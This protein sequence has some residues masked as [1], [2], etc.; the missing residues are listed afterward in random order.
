MAAGRAK[1]SRLVGRYQLVFELAQSY[2]GPL[3]AVCTDGDAAAPPSLLRLVSLG[4]QDADTRVRLLEAAWQAMEVSGDH[5][6]AVTDVVA[7]DGEL[8]VVC[9]YIEGLPLRALQGLSSA[10]RKPVPPSLA[11]RLIQDIAE[12]VSVLHGAA[13]GLGEEGA[14]L[15]GGLSPDSVIVTTEGRISLLDT[16]IAGVASTVPSLGGN[17]ER[18]AYSSPEQLGS[19]PHADARSDVFTLGVLAWELLSNRRLFIGSDKAVAQRV[20]S[21]KI[22]RPDEM[23]R[24][25]DPEVPA[26]IVATVMKALDRNPTAR[27]QSALAFRDALLG[28][29]SAVDEPEAVAEY[30]RAV[31]DGAL[32][33]LREALKD[34]STG[35]RAGVSAAKAA[36]ARASSVD[37][38]ADMAR[39]D[40]H[41]KAP[42]APKH[43]RPLPAIRLE[44]PKPVGVPKPEPKA[45]PLLAPKVDPRAPVAA[46]PAVPVP[47]T[48]DAPSPPAA[49]PPA[50]GAGAPAVVRAPVPKRL[51]T[52]IGMMSP[53]AAKPAAGPPSSDRATVKPNMRPEPDGLGEFLDDPESV[54]P[55]KPKAP[56]AAAA[57]ATF[58]HSD[59]SSLD[60]DEPTAQF[61]AKDLVQVERMARSSDPAHGPRSSRTSAA[62]DEQAP[63]SEPLAWLDDPESVRAP[64]PVA[65]PAFP[66]SDARS[67]AR[68]TPVG[69]SPDARPT[70]VLSPGALPA[71]VRPSKAAAPGAAATSPRREE[72]GS[73]PKAPVHSQPP[74]AYYPS[75][76]PPPLIHDPRANRGPSPAQ[77]AA[78][79]S[80]AS[81]SKRR[82]LVGA[83]VSLSL[84]S[85]SAIAA[86]LFLRSRDAAHD[87]ESLRVR[88][89]FVTASP[90]A[91]PEPE[92]PAT[93]PA[94]EP[95][96]SAGPDAAVA[97]A[98]A[99]SAAPSATPPVATA[100]PVAATKPAAV[101]APT[102][103]RTTTTTRKKTYVPKGL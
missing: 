45:S 48:A 20:L 78:A 10:R 40:P 32:A 60:G 31:G 34:E 5:L 14:A 52:M 63:A 19:T 24:K 18:T 91:T 95:S 79:R 22:P 50:A 75:Q 66:R 58:Q 37:L 97:S 71:E 99:P 67:E 94:P 83:L 23:K 1:E 41:A 26:S 11:L 86:V 81:R 102:T 62:R 33:R 49:S 27:F 88:G 65:Q 38:T 56:A 4:R 53:L 89:S 80:S 47:G 8:G 44:P 28:S 59:L 6:C 13:E 35:T 16:A 92:P 73:L 46:A 17:P 43:D 82:L 103:R 21:G 98:A 2:L 70:P 101:R 100:K 61:S 12:G 25:D 36:A 30:L 68:P 51:P 54:P 90:A 7:S 64:P 74:A 15:F 9:E 77:P 39:S 72:R 84:I 69:S 96:A 3:W 85:A 76:I 93:A 42:S 57:A 87:E 29:G 55:T